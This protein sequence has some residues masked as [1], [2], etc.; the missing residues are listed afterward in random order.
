M[1]W[2]LW[3]K[4][5]AVFLLGGL[6][7]ARQGWRTPAR[8]QLSLLDFLR[9]E[10]AAVGAVDFI[11]TTM[12]F[13]PIVMCTIQFIMILNAYQFVKYAAY[14]ATRS[15]IVVIPEAYQ[16]GGR[17]TLSNQKKETIRQA[18]AWAVSPVSPTKD[19]VSPLALGYRAYSSRYYKQIFMMK[20]LAKT[21]GQ[22]ARHDM[23]DHKY[24][25]AYLQTTIKVLPESKRSF[26]EF[27]GVTVEVT[28]KFHLSLPFARHILNDNQAFSLMEPLRLP[29][30]LRSRWNAGPRSFLSGDPLLGPYAKLSARCVMMNE[31]LG[32]KPSDF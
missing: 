30:F 9:D 21:R 4:Y 6:W 10:E 28:Y 7:L 32:E 1:N 15:A 8:R 29:S 18:A 27:D 14:F 20:F 24:D 19:K 26:K 23:W 13:F 22:F 11:L 2:V 17:N 25:N 5:L 16:D 3:W 31:G 12:A